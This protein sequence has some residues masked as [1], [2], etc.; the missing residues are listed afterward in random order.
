[1]E[2]IGY[3]ITSDNGFLSA[4][5]LGTEDITNIFIEK[6]LKQTLGCNDIKVNSDWNKKI[7]KAVIGYEDKSR[8][9]FTGTFRRV[10]LFA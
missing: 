8:G 9:Y 6:Y 2:I 3:E 5:V 1:M 4:I 10:K 7:W